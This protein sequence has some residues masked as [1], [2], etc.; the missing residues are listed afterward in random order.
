MLRPLRSRKFTRNG[1]S[2]RIND[3]AGILPAVFTDKEAASVPLAEF[4]RET[5]TRR[6]RAAAPPVLHNCGSKKKAPQPAKQNSAS[7]RAQEK[8][9]KQWPSEAGD[10]EWEITK[11]NNRSSKSR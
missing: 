7:R 3:H 8:P 9:P 4:E 6:A 2:V 10:M 11:N 5:M 1:G